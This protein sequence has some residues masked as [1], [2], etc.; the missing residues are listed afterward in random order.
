MGKWSKL[1]MKQKNMVSE[2]ATGSR[3]QG[4]DHVAPGAPFGLPDPKDVGPL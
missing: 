4:W 1:C 2:V 3:D